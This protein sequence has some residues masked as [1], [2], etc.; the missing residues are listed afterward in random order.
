MARGMR[1]SAS[2]SVLFIG[3]SFTGRNDLPGLIA[4]LAAARGISLQHTLVSAGG[5]SLRSLERRKPLALRLPFPF[6]PLE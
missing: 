1:C 6:G 4:Q 2:K 3:N 5:A